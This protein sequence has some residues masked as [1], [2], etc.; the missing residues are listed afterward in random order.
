MVG[1]GKFA[2]D[3]VE[4]PEEDRLLRVNA[5]FGLVENDG[6]LA[7]EN[8]FAHFFADVRR[9]GYAT[10]REEVMYRLASVAAPVLDIHGVAIAAVSITG[11]VQELGEHRDRQARLV[12]AAASRLTQIMRTRE[13][14][15]TA[16]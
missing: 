6:L 1:F 2:S 3:T 11:S 8:L 13:R 15:A 7:L 16:R 12:V 14:A 10:S 5:I 4:T 9:Q